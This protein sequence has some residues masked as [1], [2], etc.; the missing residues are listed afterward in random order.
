MPVY[1]PERTRCPASG[2]AGRL[3][4]GGRP[5]P[6]PN[7]NP[8][9]NGLRRPRAYTR[10]PSADWPPEQSYGR[11]SPAAA[12]PWSLSEAPPKAP[13]SPRLRFPMQ[14]ILL[15]AREPRLRQHHPRHQHRARRVPLDRVGRP[16]R[17]QHRWA[18]RRR[19]HQRRRQRV[20]RRSTRI[21]SGPP[22]VSNVLYI[23]RIQFRTNVVPRSQFGLSHVFCYGVPY[24]KGCFHP[25]VFSAY[26]T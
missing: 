20:R 23:L 18:R 16:S 1:P 24:L 10:W 22:V 13:I 6:I 21:D 25:S 19:C 26:D 2:R 4:S 9:T 14:A 11:S 15:R 3:K 7:S 8:P 12:Q 5:T 17:H